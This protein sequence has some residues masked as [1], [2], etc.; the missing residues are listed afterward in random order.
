MAT[1]NITD[2]SRDAREI[3]MT[4]ATARNQVSDALGAMVLPAIAAIGLSLMAHGASSAPTYPSKLIKFI[5]PFPSGSVVDVMARLAAPAL[6]VRLGQTVIVE[7]RSGGGTTIGTKSVA[8]S[9][10]DGYTLL[11][12]AGAHTLAPAL[13]KTLGYDPVK[14]FA[15]IATVGTYP[16]V[17]VVAPSVPARSVRELVDY[18]KA[19][20][21]KLNWGFGQAAG[22]HLFGELFKAATGI[23]VANIP[24]KGGTQAVPDILGGIIH[25]NFGTVSNLLPLIQEGRLRALAITSAARSPDLP[26]VPTMIESGL[27]R[28][29]RGAWTGL[30]APAKTPSS[31]VNRLNTEINASLATPEMRASMMRLGFE[32]K[33]GSPQDFAA[34]LA[35]EIEAWGTA[36]KSAGIVP[37]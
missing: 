13:T 23:D 16:W 7:N 25:M 29:T 10:T 30:L 35:D 36:A 20:P 31:I 18:A 14:D 34:L 9:A 15:S 37:Q 6:S 26:D 2:I 1:R 17:L 21:G 27:P 4:I 24:Y 3:S 5:V 32:P 22:P 19:N 8:A 33:I 28:L 11:F 12:T